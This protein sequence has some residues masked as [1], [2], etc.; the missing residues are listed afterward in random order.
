[1]ATTLKKPRSK[2]VKR[3]LATTVVADASLFFCPLSEFDLFLKKIKKSLHCDGIFCGAFLG[4]RDTMVVCE[5]NSNHYWSD[6]LVLT[7]EQIRSALSDYEILQL[8]EI[9]LDGIAPNGSPHH[10]HLFNVV[11]RA[12]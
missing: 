3:G 4:E 6:T 12:I 11:A 10:W 5:T 8:E 1:M 9:E 2:F 7:E